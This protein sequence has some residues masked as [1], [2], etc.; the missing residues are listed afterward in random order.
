[1]YLFYQFSNLVSADLSGIDWSTATSINRMFYNCA[2]LTTVT[3]PT[4]YTKELTNL[5]YLF[6][7]C[8]SLREL[9]LSHLDTSSI[10]SSVSDVFKNVALNKV[11]ISDRMGTAA[12]NVF[13][14]LSGMFV[15][16]YDKDGNPV[17]D[18]AV[19][20]ISSSARLPEDY[21]GT[22]EKVPMFRSDF[23][24]SLKKLAGNSSYYSSATDEKIKGF[25]RSETPPE[26]GTQTINLDSDNSGSI[27]GWFDATTG[28]V[29]WYSESD[30]VSTNTYAGGMFSY[31]T[32]LGTVDF[33]G[34]STS[35]STNLSNMFENANPI[36]LILSNKMGGSDGT[37]F[38]TVGL[39]TSSYDGYQ[40]RHTLIMDFTC[41]P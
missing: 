34:V 35:G 36:K 5:N 19:G 21:A 17:S 11:V 40:Y 2:S 13:S 30:L 6:E 10:T 3:L 23:N 9:D 16:T 31:M 22:W 41:S 39:N 26:T 15:K 4:G 20:T 37:K 32:K 7:G 12:Y 27:L 14:S 38:K 18:G 28:I 1:M 33:T 8:T 29:Y 24:S 25:I